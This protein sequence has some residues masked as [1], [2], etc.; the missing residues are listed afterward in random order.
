MKDS[1]YRPNGSLQGDDRPMPNRGT[2]TGMNG[3]TYGADLSDKATNRQGSITN[4]TKSNAPDE[5]PGCN[6]KEGC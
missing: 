4:H 6:N 2:G 3:D 1:N 5:M